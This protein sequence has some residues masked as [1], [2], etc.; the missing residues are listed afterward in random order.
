M[1]RTARILMLAL[2]G[3]L[4]VAGPALAFRSSRGFIV[5]PVSGP[6]FEV[7]PRGQLSD[8]EAWCAA[9]EYVSRALGQMSA[10]IWRISPP[11]RRSGQSIVFSTSSQGAAGSTGLATVGGNNGSMSASAAMAICNGLKNTNRR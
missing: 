7:R 10:R 6:Q 5:Q 8:Q 2:A 3:T 4:L 1:T 11:P 9:G